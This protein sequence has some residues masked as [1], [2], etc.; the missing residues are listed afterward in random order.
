MVEEAAI[1]TE[2][3]AV[4]RQHLDP[5]QVVGHRCIDLGVAEVAVWEMVSWVSDA[6][7]QIHTIQNKRS[8]WC[9]FLYGDVSGDSNTIQVVNGGMDCAL[10]ASSEGVAQIDK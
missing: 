7:C 3:A 2:K 10:D 8:K 6:I 1:H 4:T 5:L 9:I